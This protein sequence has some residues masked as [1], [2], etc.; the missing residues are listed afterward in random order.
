[1]NK[2]VLWYCDD[3]VSATLAVFKLLF[4]YLQKKV[5]KELKGI[6]VYTGKMIDQL[7]YHSL[8][9]FNILRDDATPMI[10]RF[11]VFREPSREKMEHF[12][13]YGYSPAGPIVPPLDISWCS[14]NDEIEA[15]RLQKMQKQRKDKFAKPPPNLPSIY[16]KPG[17]IIIAFGK[18]TIVQ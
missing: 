15:L 14:A 6:S 13:Y 18:K 8:K 9:L 12:D 7:I 2:S 10:R 3:I 11:P 17:K 5:L 16:R 1:M 4:I